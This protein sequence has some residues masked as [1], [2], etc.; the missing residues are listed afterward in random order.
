MIKK[1]ENCLYC[2]KKMDSVTAKKKFCSDLHRVYWHRMRAAADNLGKAFEEE[3]E[4][5]NNPLIS[6][7]RGRDEN[8]V[9][10][11]EVLK[12]GIKIKKYDYSA[13]PSGLMFAGR[14]A[15]KKKA[16]EEQDKLK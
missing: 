6:A 12:S 13:M 4:N 10:K 2:G 15:W 9:N 1:T 3:R 11:D 14:E 5:R 16:R 7:A 8:G